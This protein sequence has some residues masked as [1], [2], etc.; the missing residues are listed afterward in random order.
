MNNTAALL[1]TANAAAKEAADAALAALIATEHASDLARDKAAQA[2]R[3]A[4]DVARYVS[5]A[6]SAADI[7]CVAS[8]EDAV[9]DAVSRAGLAGRM[10]ARAIR[11]ANESK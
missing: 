9:F 5:Y 7:G 3:A 4:A 1:E 2:G 11:W 10:A 6:R 8:V